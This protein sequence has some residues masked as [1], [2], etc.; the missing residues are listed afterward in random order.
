MYSVVLQ[1][2]LQ[3]TGAAHNLQQITSG[4]EHVL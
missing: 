3:V 1:C 4:T 2:C